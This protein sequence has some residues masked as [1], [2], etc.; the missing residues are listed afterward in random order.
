MPRVAHTE[1]GV[2]YEAA[3]PAEPT[4]G[5]LYD[6][7]VLPDGQLHIAVVDVMGKGVG[8]TKDAL[9]LTHGLRMLALEGVDVSEL[10]PR[11]RDVM[12]E[13]N[14]ELV[15]TFVVGRYCPET[16]ELTLAGAGHPP[17]LL[18]GADGTTFYVDTGGLA[19]GWLGDFD[20]P[21][22]KLTL[23]RSDLLVLYTDGLI[24]AGK[25]II[26]GMEE[27]SHAG[28]EVADYPAPTA[29]SA[30]VRLALAAG[31]RRDD[32]LAVVLRRRIPPM[33]AG[34]RPL[35]D[36][37]HRFQ[38]HRAAVPLARKLLADWLDHQPMDPAAVD[39]LLL[40]ADELCANAVAAGGHEP[41]VMRA[42]VVGDAVVIEVEDR[43][44]GEP[45]LPPPADMPEPLAE[46]GRG[47]VLARC[48]A[49]N[50]DAHRTG[51]C[52]VVRAVKEAVVAV[53]D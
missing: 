38:P 6:W 53:P 44:G 40:V 17:P 30:L 9:T 34:Q 28:R 20:D 29:A 2:S 49:D 42:R 11:V 5:D 41:I 37:E 23:E 18:V 1:L 51:D 36:L 39:D 13:H 26:A 8:A 7:Q 16:G 22:V 4:G 3:D 50:L 12:A 25:D 19:L 31:T 27:L 47:L 48:L 33:E 52:T 15:A 45:R 46:S 43:A 24:E 14:P 32:S 35:R 10:I 21:P